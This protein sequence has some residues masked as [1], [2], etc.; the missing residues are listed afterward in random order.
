MTVRF[1]E[2]KLLKLQAKRDAKDQVSD[3]TN[4][5]LQ[6]IEA[7][8]EAVGGSM[9]TVAS[10]GG[11]KVSANELRDMLRQRQG[12]TA[13]TAGGKRTHSTSK[14]EQDAESESAS[15]SSSD[16]ELDLADLNWRAKTFG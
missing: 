9:L 2:Y 16:E 12:G 4:K 14:Q 13:S 11:S 15:E 7:G 6:E 5:K 1:W 10:A 3:S 8:A